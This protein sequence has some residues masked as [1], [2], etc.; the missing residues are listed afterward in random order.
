MNFTRLT[1]TCMFS[2]FKTL[3]LFNYM[4]WTQD[5]GYNYNLLQCS[6][7]RLMQDVLHM[8][9]IIS[10]E[11]LECILIQTKLSMLFLLQNQPLFL[12]HFSPI[13]FFFA[14]TN[15]PCCHLQIL[16]LLFPH[17]GASQY[18]W[19]LIYFSNSTQIVKLVYEINSMHTDW[20]SLSLWF[21]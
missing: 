5:L 4:K 3:P 17:T 6:H 16:C 8:E 15:G 21:F 14:F 1:P 7:T 2:F 11:T 20:S 10:V 9:S 13:S 12:L 18:I 19:K